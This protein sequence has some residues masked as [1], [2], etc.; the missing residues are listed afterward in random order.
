MPL[1]IYQGIFFGEKEIW[2]PY[3]L[4]F[5]VEK[6]YMEPIGDHLV[7]NLNQ[8]IL[9]RFQYFRR[10]LNNCGIAAALVTNFYARRPPTGPGSCFD[11]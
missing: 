2:G 8:T 6:L 4:L 1:C 7:Y 9:P 10:L 11:Q 5:F 3:A